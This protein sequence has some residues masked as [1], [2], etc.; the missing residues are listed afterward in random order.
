MD[1]QR[2]HQK[3]FLSYAFG[4]TAHYDGRDLRN[5]HKRLVE[6]MGLE[7]QHFDA[8]IEDLVLTL[9]EMGV[10]DELIAQV[11]AIA[12]TEATKQEVLNR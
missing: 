8:V 9:Q 10:S 1:A 12:N 7:S 11:G 6:E 4:G 3:A 5:A 2:Q